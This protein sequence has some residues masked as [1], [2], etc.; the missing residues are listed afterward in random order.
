MGRLLRFAR[1]RLLRAAWPRGGETNRRALGPAF[2]AAIVFS[3]V[4]GPPL[5][6]SNR[7]VRKIAPIL[8]QSTYLASLS[9][10]LHA[11]DRWSGAWALLPLAA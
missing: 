2:V 9:S 10:A 11:H 5:L 1:E 3:C 4:H 8:S 6:A 7:R